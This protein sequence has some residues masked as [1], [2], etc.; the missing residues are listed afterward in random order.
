MEDRLGA[1]GPRRKAR[2]NPRRL[3]SLV[4]P[5]GVSALACNS[6][7]GAAA[8]RPA[9]RALSVR[10]APVAVQDVVYEIRAVGSLE[11]EELVQITAEVEG[12]VSEVRFH[13]GDRVGPQ[14]V[15]ARIDPDRYRLEAQR[16]EASFQKARADAERARTD[17]KRREELAAQQL[18]AAEELN[19]ARAEAEQLVAE[20]EATRAARDLAQQSLRKSEVRPPRAGVI[21]TRT[22][23]TGQFVRTGTALATLVDVSRLRLRFKVSEGESLRAREGQPV[24]F[25]VS[26]L[27]ERAFQAGVYHVGEVADP[28]TRQVEVLAWVKNPGELKPG[29]FAE[30]TLASET[31]KGAV[32]VPEGAI[33]ASDRGFVT[34]VVEGDKVRQRTVQIGLRTGTGV[35][36]ILSGVASGELVVVEGSDRLADGV[37]VQPVHGGGTGDGGGGPKSTGSAR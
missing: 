27:G 14:T 30:V 2:L 11:A 12:A 28:A 3:L 16:A 32:I 9:A 18:V 6:G 17:L 24:S 4:L 22:V 35:V 8:G 7:Q 13:E 1:V 37:T 26:A 5:L 29:F 20:A 25:R 36:E 33:Q 23:E 19:R 10:V 31:R 34:Y 15:L 21:N